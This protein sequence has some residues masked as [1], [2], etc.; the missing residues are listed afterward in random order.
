MAALRSGVKTVIIPAENERD[1]EDIDQDVR[2]ALEFVPTD[3]IDKILN[4]ALVK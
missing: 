4:I 2:A 1:L 3:R